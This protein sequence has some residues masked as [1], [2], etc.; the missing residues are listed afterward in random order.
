MEKSIEEY[1]IPFFVLHSSF[2]FPDTSKPSSVKTLDLSGAVFGGCDTDVE[3]GVNDVHPLP[4]IQFFS[5]RRGA[6]LP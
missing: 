4:C 2:I 5:L 3:F 6:V 1:R